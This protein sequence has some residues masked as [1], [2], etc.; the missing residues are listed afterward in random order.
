M[1]QVTLKQILSNCPEGKAVGAFNI[2]NLEFIK[3]VVSA[4]E[5]ENKPVIMMI[6]EGV[7]KY[8]SIEVLGGAAMAAAKASSVDVA[9]MVD[10]GGN[11]ELLKKSLD[12]GLDVMFDGSHYPFEENIALTKEMADYA[13]N[14]GRSLEGEIG[15]LGLSED[16]DESAEE[17]IT[18]VAEAIAFTEQTGVDVL[19]ISVG[20]VHGF[21]KG[22]SNIRIDRVGEIHQAMPAVPVVMHGGSDL[23]K[24][25]VQGSIKAGIRKFN[26]ATDLKQAYALKMKELM[27]QESMPIQPLELFPVAA[28]A[29]AEVVS[30]KIKMFNLEV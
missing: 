11:I 4:A 9:V 19:A 17:K 21:Y 8:G 28:A 26:I 14:L 13:H 30:E 6:N 12:A 10:H 2:H 24:E 5:Q 22:K 7:L 23:S 20:N 18:T 25:V 27:T 16:G 29:V 1:P 15:V 3:G